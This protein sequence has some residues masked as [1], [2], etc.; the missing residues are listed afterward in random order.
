MGREANARARE[1]EVV[2]RKVF[3]NLKYGPKKGPAVL[4]VF[5]QCCVWIY[6]LKVW[7]SSCSYA[8][9]SLRRIT[10]ILKMAGQKVGKKLGP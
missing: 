4:S 8:R 5:E 7:Q 10:K 2:F 1:R 9:I 6:K 3:L